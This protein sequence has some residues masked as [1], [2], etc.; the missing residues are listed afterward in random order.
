M[1][2]LVHK[3]FQFHSLQLVVTSCNPDHQN[4][5]TVGPTERMVV[6]MYTIFK[7]LIRPAEEYKRYK[8]YENNQASIAS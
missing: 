6:D 8:N 3:G 5:I 4:I 2:H 7:H 1:L